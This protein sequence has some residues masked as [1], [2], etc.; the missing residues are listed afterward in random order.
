MALP[1]P[2]RWRTSTT[3]AARAKAPSVSAETSAQG[4]IRSRAKIGR[5]TAI[6]WAF[7]DSRSV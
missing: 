1:W 3:P 5:S 6:G 4:M 7:S 2:G